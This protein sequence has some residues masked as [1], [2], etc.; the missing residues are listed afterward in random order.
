[1][2]GSITPLGERSRGSNWWIT[3]G[4]F[5]AGASVSG[6]ALGAALGLAGGGLTD[7]FDLSLT[8]RVQLF[9]LVTAT[10][11]LVDL[12]V[13]KVPSGLRQVNAYWIGRYRSWFVGLGF[14][15]QLGLGVGTIVTTALVYSSLASAVL[16][17]SASQG[18]IL[19][20]MFGAARGLALLPAASVR[21]PSSLYAMDTWLARHQ[22]TAQ[23]VSAAVAIAAAT[24]V[25]ATT[26]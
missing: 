17:S 7:L 2:L 21:T 24:I 8:A 22:R 20:G 12:A 3:F 1:M 16:V 11:V 19:M 10:A 26:I 5:V 23:W 6:T 25:L 13:R 4:W 14:G 9:A 18:A 15:L